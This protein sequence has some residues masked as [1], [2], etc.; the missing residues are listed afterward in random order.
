MADIA[1]RRF[2]P[3]DGRTVEIRAAVPADAAAMLEYLEAV[4]GESD[5]LTF[6]PGE[7]ELTEAQEAEHLATRPQGARSPAHRRYG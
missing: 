1:A 6:G 3:N 2:T 7:F 5:F 4:S